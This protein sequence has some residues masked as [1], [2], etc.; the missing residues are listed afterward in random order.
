MIVE[1]KIVVERE[2]IKL[3]VMAEIKLGVTGYLP[4]LHI[5]FLILNADKG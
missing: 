5:D 3:I 2:K 4:T 1:V